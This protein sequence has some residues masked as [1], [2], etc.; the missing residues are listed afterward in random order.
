MFVF[1]ILLLNCPKQAKTYLLSVGYRNMF[2]Q[3]LL[4]N[5]YAHLHIYRVAM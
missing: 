4:K 3:Q 5:T 1:R 2:A